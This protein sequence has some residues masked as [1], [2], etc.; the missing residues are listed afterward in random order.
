MDRRLTS[1]PLLGL[2]LGT[3]FGLLDGLSGFFYPKLAAIMMRVIF[4][5]TL[6]G[7]LAGLVIGLVAQRVNSLAVGIAVG[8]A[9][10]AITSYLLVLYAGSQTFWDIVPPGM[11]LGVIVGFATVKLG[12]RPEPA[13]QPR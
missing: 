4:F 12:R 7:V 13:T 2:L 5:S 11:L 8:L 9:V 1:R 3:V 6:K 10:G